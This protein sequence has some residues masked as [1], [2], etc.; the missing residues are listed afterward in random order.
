M[1]AAR[2]FPC[3]LSIREAIELQRSLATE[4]IEKDDGSPIRTVAG[5]DMSIR[6]SRARAA[7]VVLELP[8]LRVLDERVI[9]TK[10]TFPYVPGLLSFREIPPL[11]RALEKCEADLLMADGQGLA[12]PRLFGLACHLGLVM[13]KPAIGCAKS[14]LCGEVAEP[15]RAR[16]STRPIGFRGRTVGSAVRTREGVR[17]VFVSVGH[18]ISLRTAVR[19]VLLCSRFRIP[20]PTRLADRLARRP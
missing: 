10:V 7:A 16:G 12:H 19:I 3:G 5:L 14:L 15:A 13:D 18:R 2:K 17:P 9:E 4:V 8:S 20:E 6:G 1:K 11:V